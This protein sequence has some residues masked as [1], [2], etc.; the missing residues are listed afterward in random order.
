MKKVMLL[1]KALKSK[2]PKLYATE[3][4]AAEDK[5]IFVKIFDPFSRFTFYGV[6]YDPDE[7]VFFGW[8]KSALDP[9]FDELGYASLT[10]LES[11]RTKFGLYLERDRYY[12]PDKYTIGDVKSGSTFAQ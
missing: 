9:D 3:D 5:K 7:R 2:I 8:T 6:E 1:T 11:V 12:T 4:V 10:E